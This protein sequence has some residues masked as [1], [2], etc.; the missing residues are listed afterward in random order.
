M[1]GRRGG[2]GLKKKG[3]ET[4]KGKRKKEGIREG[5]GNKEEGE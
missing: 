1:L 5:R 4:R 3:K 2:K